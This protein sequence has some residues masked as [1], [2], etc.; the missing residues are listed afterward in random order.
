MG[1]IPGS[2]GSPGGVHGNPPQYSCLDN[3]MD[4][5]AYSPQG[6]KESDTT[7]VT[8]HACQYVMNSLSK[9]KDCI[10]IFKYR[11]VRKNESYIKLQG[12]SMRFPKTYSL[13]Y[14]A[15]KLEIEFLLGRETLTIWKFKTKQTKT[16][17]F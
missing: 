1:S 5:G 14:N 3:P 7:E 10:L 12:K 17:I 13:Y 16:L 4:R 9:S 2:G 11:E 6:C 8:Q 15:I